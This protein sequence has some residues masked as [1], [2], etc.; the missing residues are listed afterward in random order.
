MYLSLLVLNLRSRTVRR[1]LADCRSM[2]RTILS[3]FPQSVR[4]DGSARLEFGVLY[5]VE[6]DP[7]TSRTQILVQS[8]ELPDWSALPTDYL[9]SDFTT[10]DNP[11]LKRIDQLYQTFTAGM[12]LKFRLRANPT[13]RISSNCSTELSNGQGKRVEI[14]DPIKQVQWLS[15]K[16]TQHGFQLISL[17][18]NQEIP[19]L[20]ARPES[21]SIGWRAPGQSPMKFGVVTFEGI[22]EVSDP[23]QFTEALINGIGSGKAYG[24]GLLSIAPVS[25]QGYKEEE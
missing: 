21:K 10:L 16:A 6:S 4:V 11:A 15:R 17:R 12:R 5:R 22:L 24:F 3:A 25:N 13:R 19:N 7:R 8:Q 1:D 23:Q 9:A 14:Y 20:I 18:A 2:H